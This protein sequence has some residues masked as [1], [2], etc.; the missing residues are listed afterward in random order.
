M[1]SK[2][3]IAALASVCMC[4]MAL[5]QTRISMF[6]L[7]DWTES[8]TGVVTVSAGD[9]YYYGGWTVE[10]VAEDNSDRVM[11]LTGL[12]TYEVAQPLVVDYRNGTVLL[13]A[14]SDEPFATVSG[15]STTVSDG[16]TTRV[17]SVVSY[18]VVNQ[19]WVTGGALADVTGEVL[20]DGTIHIPG[21]FAYYIETQR[22]TTITE[23]DGSSRSF[24]DQTDDVSRIFA[25][26]WLRVANGKHEFTDAATGECRVVDVCL[27]QSGDT[28]WVTNIYGY[29]A[30]EV[31]MVLSEDGTMSYP[32]QMLRDIPDEVATSG[33]GLWYN[34]TSASQEGNEGAVTPAAITWGTTVAWNHAMTW[35]GWTDNKLYYSDGTEFD[36]P[37]S[38]P[39]W[40]PGDVNHDGKVDV[41]DVSMT[42]N[43]V[44]GKENTNA[45]Y[46]AQ[47]DINGDGKIDV[48]DVSNIINIVLG[49]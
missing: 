44:L 39:Q 15:T 27:R 41:A 32:S 10:L 9:P 42:I 4:L 40:Q 35:S 19:E 18:Y 43:R 33:E 46:E 45:F 29:G 38:E 1:M 5:G 34:A 2:R 48:S 7:Y 8:P 6:H 13:D 37:G 23:R 49:K 16:T 11:A 36:V 24:T 20:A 26:L 31:Y 14:T 28:V 3:Q 47:G 25:D 22:T 30:P 17:D 21:G 12:T